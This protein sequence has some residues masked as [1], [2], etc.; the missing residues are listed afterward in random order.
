MTNLMS[1]LQIGRCA[2]QHRV[3]MA[4]LT[5]YRADAEHVHT[6]LGVE[7]YAQ[8]ASTPGTLL[9]TEAT[10]IAKKAGGYANVPALENDAQ[11]KAWKKVCVFFLVVSFSLGWE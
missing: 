3:V 2:L 4:P 10:F 1:P 7:Y 5:R 8:R 9:I 11:V 6:D